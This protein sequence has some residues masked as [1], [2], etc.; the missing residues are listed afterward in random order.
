MPPT[1][2]P[3]TSFVHFETPESVSIR[4]ET[5]GLG[6]RAAALMIDGAVLFVLSMVV[7]VPVG[8]VVAALELG[9]S[10]FIAVLALWSLVLPL[11][12]FPWTAATIGASFG[13]RALG[14]RVVDAEGRSAPLGAHLLRTLALF[15][16]TLVPAPGFAVGAVA[17]L[18]SRDGKR[19]GDYLAGTLVVRDEVPGAHDRDPLASA[20]YADPAEPRVVDLPVHRVRALD[21]GALVLLRSFHARRGSLDP[22]AEASLRHAI[23]QRMAEELEIA[24][25]ADERGF[26]RQLYLCLRDERSAR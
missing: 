15:V 24:L 20:R 4:W 12:Y 21:A 10:T 6:S 14:I 1:A 18:L 11:A 16:D 9:Q 19:L 5:A 26:L 7:L 2:D 22:G 23:A 13:K 8:I 25:P 17:I 3:S